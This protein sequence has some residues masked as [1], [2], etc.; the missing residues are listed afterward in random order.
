MPN[1]T[2]LARLM[3][4]PIQTRMPERKAIS[5][6]NADNTAERMNPPKQSIGAAINDVGG[7][8]PRNEGAWTAIKANIMTKPAPPSFQAPHAHVNSAQTL[9]PALSGTNRA[10][11]PPLHKSSMAT[12]EHAVTTPS[13]GAT[14]R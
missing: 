12:E 4:S 10:S 11:D 9:P 2:V 14:Q 5:K 3:P 13:T 1:N 7:S 8:A 6:P